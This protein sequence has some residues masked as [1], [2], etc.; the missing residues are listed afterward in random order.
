MSDVIPQGSAE[1][2]RRPFLV[3]L[4]Q[5]LLILCAVGLSAMAIVLW[6]PT[7]RRALDAGVAPW[8]IAA[9]AGVQLAMISRLVALFVGLVQRR[10]WAWYGS[11]AFAIALLALLIHSRIDL[12]PDG[13]LQLLPIRPEE[14]RGAAIGEALVFILVALYPFGLFFSRKARRFFGRAP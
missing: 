4:T 6:P 8:R 9:A 12:P 1:R 14:R 3:W 10:R 5:V 7:V 2:A 13:P 11:L